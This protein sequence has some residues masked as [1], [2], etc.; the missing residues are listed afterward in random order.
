MRTVIG[1]DPG[2]AATGWGVVRFDGSRFTHV[3]H[4]VVTTNP[5]TPLSHRLLKIYEEI[6]KVL[7]AHRP[8]EAGVEDLFF[9]QNATSAMQVA[10]ARGVVMLALAQSR[11]EVGTY[12]PQQVKQAVIGR[13]KAAKEQVQRLVGVVLGLEEL[14]GPD[15]AADALAVAICHAN[16][17][18]V[19]VQ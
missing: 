4:G 9:S 3:G 6:R 8:S 18:H 15:H 13:G 11:I 12:S 5:G 17:S 16:R 10:Q 19:H 2:L 14:P 1:I 7:T